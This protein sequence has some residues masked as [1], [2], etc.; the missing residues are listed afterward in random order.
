MGT[1]NSRKTDAWFYAIFGSY[2]AVGVFLHLSYALD[3]KGL[4]GIWRNV[5]Y[6]V[7]IIAGLVGFAAAFFFA[8]VAARIKR[9]AEKTISI[10]I[11][12]TSIFFGAAIAL[13]GI[14]FKFAGDEAL[15]HS[16]LTPGNLIP[17]GGFLLASIAAVI[18]IVILI[19]NSY[20]IMSRTQLI[21][22]VII[23]LVILG[24]FV[25]LFFT[26]LLGIELGGVVKIAS[27]FLALVCIFAS[28]GMVF[29]ITAFGKGRG[30]N[31]WRDLSVGILLIAV[32]GLGFFFCLA[33]KADLWK[34]LPIMGF[35][36]GISFIAHAGYLR[37]RR[38][39]RK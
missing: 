1:N 35:A 14:L 10:M 34:G 28:V 38:L 30:G 37:W 20:R 18:A 5:S 26:K 2:L 33:L 39:R 9:G 29:A 4:S 32:S 7:E 24:A 3:I 15:T 31:F 23:S 13:V 21:V 11:T 25:A 17:L 8:T 36:A 27:L 19:R 12:L 16:F 6:I 22:T